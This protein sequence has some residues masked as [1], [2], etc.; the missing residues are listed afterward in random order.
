MSRKRSDLPRVRRQW[1]HGDSATILKA[2]TPSSV[3]SMTKQAGL[4]PTGLT[5][6]VSG[7]CLFLPPRSAICRGHTC[8]LEMASRKL[9]TP[10]TVSAQFLQNIWVPVSLRQSRDPPHSLG[11]SL[12]LSLLVEMKEH[13]KLRGF[14]ATRTLIVLIETTL[15]ISKACHYFQILPKHFQVSRLTIKAKC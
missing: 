6:S 8:T 11:W 2:F 13:S 1:I 4:L 15:I 12:H 3:P 10:F 5:P 7:L 9:I 14:P